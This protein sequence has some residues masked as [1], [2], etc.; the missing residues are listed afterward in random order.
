MNYPKKERNYGFIAQIIMLAVLIAFLAF[1][2]LSFIRSNSSRIIEQNNQFIEA[3]AEQTADHFNDL[4]RSAQTNASMASHVYELLKMETLDASALADII[5][6]SIFDYAEFISK[7]GTDLTAKGETADLSDR[8]YFIDGMSGKSGRCVIHNSRITNETL[9]IFYTP[10]RHDG[11]IVG[12]LSC[13]L[14]GD[15]LREMLSTSYFGVQGAT[16]LLERD[17]SVIIS[18][19]TSEEPSNLTE[20]F[21]E[22]GNIS[23]DDLKL[24]EDALDSTNDIDF[25]SFNYQGKSGSG[26]AYITVL[27]GGDWFLVESFPSSVTGEMTSRANSAGIRLMIMLLIAFLAYLAYLVI[28]NMLQRR[29]LLTENKEILNIIDATSQLFTRFALVDYERN[30]YEYLENKKSTAPEKGSYTELMSYLSKRYIESG[31]GEKTADVISPEYVK[32]H[33]TKDVPYLQHEYEI[34]MNGRRW[35]N[36]SIICISR[37]NGKPERVLYA[38]QDVTAL[39]EREQQI[40]LA[41]KNSTEAAEAANRAKSDFLARMSHDI[42][43][44]MNAIMGMTAVAAMHIDDKERLTDCLSK[45]TISSRHLLALIND[46]LDMSKIES[47]KVSLSEEPFS[48]AD[49]VD[50]V[51]TIIKAQVKPKRQDLKVHINEI[52]HENVIGDHLRLRQVLLNILGNAVKF[53]PEEGKINFEIREC[54]SR[55]NGMACFEFVCE[56]NGMGMDKE[57]LKTIFD[58]FSRAGNAKSIEGTGLGMPIT[59]NIVRM[60]SGEI[61]VES[62]PG[63][64]SKFTVR[65][66][67]KIQARD[68]EDIKALADLAVLVADDDKDSCVTT[69]DILSGIGMKPEYVLSGRE[70]VSKTVEAHDSGRGYSALILDW[71]M[72]GMDG[73]E[74]AREIRKKI[75]DEL[76]ILILS[77]YDWTDIEAEARQAGIQAFIEKPLFRSRLIYALKSV[78]SEDSEEG[79]KLVPDDLKNAEFKGRRVLLVEDN[80]LNLEIATE[81]LSYTGVEVESAENGQVAVDKFKASGEGYYDLV[82]MDIQMPVMNGYEAAVN[83]RALDRQDSGKVPIIAMT[84]NAFS[85]DIFKAHEAGMNDHISKPVEVEKLIEALRKW[86]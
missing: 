82:F 70:A 33:L 44:P 72:P 53:T 7:D 29:K 3:A 45:I 81:L 46:V 21:K 42:R 67:L 68:A 84:A 32:S 61:S 37:K 80:E 52:D 83:I 75:G 69:C 43:T 85:D 16:Y 24:F 17:G 40:R 49:M 78:L 79:N 35:E 18:V 26:S 19:G 2:F 76:P 54:E 20:Y 64:G 31:D 28:K 1:A 55:I 41:L 22:T 58:P 11:E 12:V 5:D 56:D 60:M 50:S 39:K 8:E 59:R 57:F 86:L 66:H 10:F 6:H 27:E 9:L 62:E 34:D 25:N 48:I 74:T 65:L 14:R 73:V 23:D 4:L 15:T 51:V 77:A 38:I 36:V 71:K 63:K 13:I 47:G 30:A